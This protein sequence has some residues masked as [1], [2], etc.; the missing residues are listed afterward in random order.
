MVL[1]L[2]L[3]FPPQFWGRFSQKHCLPLFRSIFFT[4]MRWRKAC[5]K[6]LAICFLLQW[7]AVLLGCPSF[8]KLIRLHP[9]LQVFNCVLSAR[10]GSY[11]QNPPNFMKFCDETWKTTQQ[12]AKFSDRNFNM[13][14]PKNQKVFDSVKLCRKFNPSNHGSAL[15]QANL[16]EKP[17]KVS[18]QTGRKPK[19]CA[20]LFNPEFACTKSIKSFDEFTHPSR[21]RV[22]IPTK[23]VWLT[24]I[25]PA[26]WAMPLL[27]V[28]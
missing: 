28:C 11:L 3:I 6:K 23:I 10:V 18:C 27:Y 9:K 5:R 21:V 1:F 15:R 22:D 25:I 14:R 13:N 26:W 8:I 12:Q 7:V 2:K 19:Q 17:L 24:N 4:K 20:T 16:L